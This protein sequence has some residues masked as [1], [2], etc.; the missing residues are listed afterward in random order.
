MHDDANLSELVH[1]GLTRTQAH[2][3]L[4]ST[5]IARSPDMAERSHRVM[6]NDGVLF[7]WHGHR[8]R[9]RG[10]TRCLVELGV[11]G[12][13]LLVEIDES[14]LDWDNGSSR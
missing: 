10:S 7:G 13:G 8:I 11:N 1:S 4:L 3:A 9:S 6:I 5:P 12:S 2:P 14:L